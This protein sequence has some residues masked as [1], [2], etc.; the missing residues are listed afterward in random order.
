[1][2]FSGD[3]D[4]EALFVFLNDPCPS[5]DVMLAGVV[6]GWLQA[7]SAQQASKRRGAKEKKR[8]TPDDGPRVQSAARRSRAKRAG[9]GRPTMFPIGEDGKGRMRD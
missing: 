1:M 4:S 5:M 6:Q 9:A 3:K 8:E 7:N 2:D